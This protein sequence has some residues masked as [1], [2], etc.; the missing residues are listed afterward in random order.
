MS[1]DW[2]PLLLQDLNSLPFGLERKVPD[3][4]SIS[5]EHWDNNSCPWVLLADE[6][7]HVSNI[8]GDRA[9]VHEAMNYFLNNIHVLREPAHDTAIW[10]NIEEE[11]YCRRDVATAAR[12][13]GLECNVV[14]AL[15]DD[16]AQ[17]VNVIRGLVVVVDKG[18]IALF[19]GE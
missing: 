1:Y 8:D 3:I 15:P 6:N 4:L 10:G 11:V 17:H 14:H 18:R 12:E 13:K 5:K 9:A 19:R 2:R 7:E 16:R